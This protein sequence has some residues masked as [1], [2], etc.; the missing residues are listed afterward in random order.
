MKDAWWGYRRCMRGV[1]MMH[2]GRQDGAF[3]YDV[4]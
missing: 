3:E 4:V 1:C 2:G